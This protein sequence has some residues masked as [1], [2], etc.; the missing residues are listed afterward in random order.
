MSATEPEALG[1][2]AHHSHSSLLEPTFYQQA[3]REIT[4]IKSSPSVVLL[5]HL[6]SL[7]KFGFS[8]L[9]VW[10]FVSVKQRLSCYTPHV[11]SMKIKEFLS[12]WLPCSIY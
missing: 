7:E 2:G 12:C 8:F 10:Y 1:D 9:F 3:P 4:M 5:F 6:D 11:A